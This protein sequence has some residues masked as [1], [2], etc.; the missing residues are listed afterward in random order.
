LSGVNLEGIEFDETTKWPE[1][2]QLKKARNIP[3]KLR[4]QLGI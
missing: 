1:P 3:Q 2:E 4:E